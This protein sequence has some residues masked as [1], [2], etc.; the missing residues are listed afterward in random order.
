MNS[1]SILLPA[2][3]L[4]WWSIVILALVS[5]RRLRPA[6]Q[7]GG[8]VRDFVERFALGEPDD[9]PPGAT[10]A[11]RNWVNLLESPV[12]FY[13]SCVTLLVADGVTVLA[14]WLAWAY[15]AL[16]IL[17]SLVHVL[18]NRVSHRSTVFA[19]SI[20]VLCALMAKASWALL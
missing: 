12:L 10:A 15:V 11:N 3:A 8:G 14:V 2:M 4:A 17:H 9:T 13:L 18:Y 16:R 7:S 20:A 6:R 19:F 5:A 1:T